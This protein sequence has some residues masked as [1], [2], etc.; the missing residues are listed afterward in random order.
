MAKK[1]AI[2]GTATSTVHLANELDDTWDIWSCNGA[3]DLVKRY[4]KHFE[5][6]DIGYLRSINVIPEY[7]EWFKAQ[8]SKVILQK[9]YAE[10]PASDVY[11]INEIIDKLGHSYFNNTIAY[12]IAYAIYNNPD[13]ERIA[14]YGVDMAA[15]GEY[16]HQRPCCEFWLG[17]ALAKGIVLDIPD[18]CPIAKST[19]LYGFQEAPPMVKKMQIMKEE[20]NKRHKEREAKRLAA[21]YDF[22]HTK[23]AKEMLERLSGLYL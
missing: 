20:M 21:D 15:D 8:G 2:V 14:L 1:I 23:G 22:Y 12:M 5:L 17:Y 18:I 10:F 13:L 19:H 7:L 3:Y 11:P 4:D 16:R 9:R 6:H